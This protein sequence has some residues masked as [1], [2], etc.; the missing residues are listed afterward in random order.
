MLGKT[1]LIVSHDRIWLLPGVP[2]APQAAPRF[3]RREGK[4]FEYSPRALCLEMRPARECV[5]VTSFREAQFVA[6]RQIRRREKSRPCA[7]VNLSENA[8]EED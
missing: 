4:E 5:N 2:P 1:P 6:D 8:A 7:R 3:V